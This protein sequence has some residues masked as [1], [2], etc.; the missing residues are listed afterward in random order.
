M[1]V[2]PLCRP[3]LLALVLAAA[4]ST[5]GGGDITGGDPAGGADGGGNGG[6]SDECQQVEPVQVATG[7]PADLLLVVDKSGSME[8]PLETGQDKWPV[9]RDALTTVVQQ[10]ENGIRFGLMLYPDG[11]SCAAGSVRSELAMQNAGPVTGQLGS[12]FPDGGT[13]THTTLAA[14]GAYYAGV[15]SPG[16]RYVLLAT[17][18]EPNCA[19]GDDE[20]PTVT[21]SIQAIGGLRD[22]GIM[23]FVL[24]FGGTIN[25]YPETLQ[26]MAEAGG[27]G[28]YFAANSPDEL[29]TALDTIAGE[30]GLP[31][32]SFRLDRTPG[33]ASELI[34][35]QDD[36]LISRDESHLSGWDYATG[37]NTLTFY[38]SA[39]D[40]ILGGQTDNVRIQFGG[41]NEVE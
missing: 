14:A 2:R 20:A 1:S 37:N 39:C 3:D 15:S 29:A 10:Y 30:V 32:C 16:A 6:V 35:Y 40:A 7:D 26:A 18:G 9:M 11:D 13:P 33:S 12:T 4:C 24:G 25:N 34:V 8:D 22:D 28:D 41:C 23:T 19:P 27:T 5:V 38:G 21:E 31:S 36:E 17:D